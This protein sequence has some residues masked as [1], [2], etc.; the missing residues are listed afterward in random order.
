MSDEIVF[1][2][3]GCLTP[4]FGVCGNC[5]ACKD[6]CDCSHCDDC[7][8]AAETFDCYPHGN[9]CEDCLYEKFA[10]T[11]CEILLSLPRELAPMLPGF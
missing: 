2:Y 9:L 5:R 1:A 3:C 7:G 11:E 4:E 10:K 8:K 6:C